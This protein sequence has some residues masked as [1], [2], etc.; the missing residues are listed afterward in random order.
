MLDFLPGKEELLQLIPQIGSIAL[1]FLLALGILALPIPDETLLIMAGILIGRGALHPIPTLIAAYA[2]SLVGVSGSYLIGRFIS[3]HFL[4]K[5]GKKIGLTKKKLAKVHEWFERFGKWTLF[6]GYFVPGIRHLT[7]ISSGIAK[8]EFHE[9]ALFAYSG[10]ILWVSLFL[11]LGYFFG[12]YGI[13]LV[14]QLDEYL[15]P[16]LIFVTLVLILCGIF[17]IRHQINNKKN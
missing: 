9:F 17:I 2:G 8:L 16:T 4:E 14:E 15:D 6:F 5:Y 11:F 12:D 3:T 7:G 1:F 13:Y 10:G